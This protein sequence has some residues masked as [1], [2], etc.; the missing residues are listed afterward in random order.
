MSRDKG[1]RGEAEFEREYLAAYGLLHGLDYVREQDGRTQ[2][3]DFRVGHVCIDVKRR[4]RIDIHGA[5]REIEERTPVHL[6]PVIAY[7]KS[8]EPWRVSMT[9]DDFF[10]LLAAS[11][12]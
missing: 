4:E 9:A 5:S 8:H 6:V 7:R 1:K 11:L 2:G 12:K 3:A 10:T